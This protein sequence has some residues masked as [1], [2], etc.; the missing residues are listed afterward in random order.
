[1]RLGLFLYRNQELRNTEQWISVSTQYII[2]SLA[3]LGHEVYPIRVSQLNIK[4]D[5]AGKVVDVLL[6]D[7]TSLSA[8][9][10]DGVMSRW[11]AKRDTVM[12][13]Q[14]Y[15]EGKGVISSPH[16]SAIKRI[17]GKIAGLKTLQ[18]AGV[19]TPKSLLVEDD[20]P[21]DDA[22]YNKLGSPPYVVKAN[23]GTRGKS[24]F[25]IYSANDAIRKAQEIIITGD[26][27]GAIIEEFIPPPGMEKGEC[28]PQNGVDVVPRIQPE[29][30]RSL[31][32]G[33]KIHSTIHQKV[34]RGSAEWI[35]NRTETVGKLVDLSQEQ[36]AIVLKAAHAFGFRES[37]IDFM[38]THEEEMVIL[39]VNHS[40]DLEDHTQLGVPPAESIAR[41]FCTYVQEVKRLQTG[42]VYDPFSAQTLWSPKVSTSTSNG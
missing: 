10:L 30:F 38:F 4:R 35:G 42:G 15:L 18:A 2:D 24:V 3:G 40:P 26:Q 5:L 33:E 23:R 41:G 1:M 7:N 32:I 6:P 12:D 22:V 34:P 13:V 19:A 28:M 31:V 16:S 8:L 25:V 17:P 11:S 29:Y 36:T 9:H 39:E 20:V 14:Q 21:T 37:G 27:A